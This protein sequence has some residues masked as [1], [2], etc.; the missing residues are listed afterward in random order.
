MP[1]V[2]VLDRFVPRTSDEDRSGLTGDIHKAYRAN[3][4]I[5]RGDLLGGGL[6]GGKVYHAGCFIGAGAH[7]FGTVLE[8]MLSI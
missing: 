6:A 8:E 4:L 2:P 3:R 1:E 7:D 5:M